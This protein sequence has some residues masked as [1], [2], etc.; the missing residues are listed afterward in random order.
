MCGLGREGT[1]L[2]KTSETLTGIEEQSPACSSL[3]WVCSVRRITCWFILQRKKERKRTNF[4]IKKQQNGAHTHSLSA[5]YCHLHQSSLVGCNRR[6]CHCHFHRCPFNFTLY[7]FVTVCLCVRVSQSIDQSVNCLGKCR[8]ME[9]AKKDCKA[10]FATMAKAQ[11]QNPNSPQMLMASGEDNLKQIKL[12]DLSTA[13]V[14]RAPPQPGAR[15]TLGV[16]K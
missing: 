16:I 7:W 8:A 9:G 3:R 13:T 11:K 2:S 12:F 10:A 14:A 4:K 15:G 5:N 1:K 6:P